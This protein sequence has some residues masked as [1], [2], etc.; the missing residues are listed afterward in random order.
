MALF[1]KDKKPERRTRTTT[2]DPR[3][4]DRLEQVAERLEKVSKELENRLAEMRQEE[5]SAR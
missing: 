3:V 5:E 2:L 1:K 4:T